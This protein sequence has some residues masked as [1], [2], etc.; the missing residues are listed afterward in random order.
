M[1]NTYLGMQAPQFNPATVSSIPYKP[2]TFERLSNV[3]GMTY[4][5]SSIENINTVSL[6]RG[7]EQQIF[8]VNNDDKIYTR[9]FDNSIGIVGYKQDYVERLQNELTEAQNQLHEIFE[10]VS[11]QE[12]EEQANSTSSLESRITALEQ[13]FAS[14][15]EEPPTNERTKSGQVMAAISEMAKA[16]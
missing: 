11:K 10:S 6:P 15:K 5:L 4:N 7:G 1:N 8:F 3:I 13:Q 2:V 12:Q 16:E 14:L 9:A